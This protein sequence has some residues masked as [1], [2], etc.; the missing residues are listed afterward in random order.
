MSSTPRYEL[1]NP[2]D[3]DLNE[4]ASHLAAD[5]RTVEEFVTDLNLLLA[6]CRDQRDALP[7]VLRS[8]DARFRAANE[9]AVA[10]LTGSLRKALAGEDW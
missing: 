7:E 3:D 2:S 4:A 9:E 6:D 10:E 5:I 1:P 8:S